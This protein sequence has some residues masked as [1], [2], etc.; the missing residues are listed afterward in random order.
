MKM[1]HW[2]IGMLGSCGVAI[3]ALAIAVPAAAVMDEATKEAPEC[4][5]REPLAGPRAEARNK[6]FQPELEAQDGSE[7][8]DSDSQPQSHRGKR[9]RRGGVKKDFERNQKGGF[10]RQREISQEMVDKVMNV[11]ETALP[12]W[13]DRLAA[14]REDHPEKFKR[15]IRRVFPRVREYVSLRDHKPELAQTVIE[16][17]KIEHRLRELSMQY[18]AAEADSAQQLELDSLIEELVRKQFDFRMQR[19]KAHLEEV[20]RR[21]QREREKYERELADQEMMISKR[22]ERI[23]QGK[24]RQKFRSRG[25][26]RE[27]SDSFKEKS[28]RRS[29][30]S[31]SSN[32]E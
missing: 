30:H 4:A 16:E 32:E 10:R 1:H 25:K 15:V 20:E 12:E 2:K 29:K 18:Q 8:A 17:F 6:A 13:H 19:R 5:G 31:I 9:G 7:D 14:L 28:R 23:K 11:L 24:F 26:F 22:I 21:L 27:R 3:V